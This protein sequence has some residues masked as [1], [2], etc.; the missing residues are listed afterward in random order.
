MEDFQINKYIDLCKLGNTGAFK[1]IVSKY[2]QLVYT[3]AFKMLCNEVDAEDITQ[4]TFIKV[5][6]NI[7]R[8]RNQY[9]F[10]T[11]IYKIAANACYDKLRSKQIVEEVSL[12]GYDIISEINQEELLQNKELKELILKLTF[13]LS[14]KQ[15]LIFTLSEIDDLTVEEIIQITGMTPAKIKSNLYLAKKYI[16]SKLSQYE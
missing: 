8:Y 7:S 14:P 5:W 10:S 1:Y 4:E 15:Q 3:L 2:Q 13:G 6:Q 16:K 9:K 11:W 12:T